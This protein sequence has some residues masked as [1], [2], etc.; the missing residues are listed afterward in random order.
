LILLVLLAGCSNPMDAADDYERILTPPCRLESDV[1]LGVDPGQCAIVC[2]ESGFTVNHSLS[3]CLGYQCCG[4]IGDL[5]DWNTA[6]VL[7][8]SFQHD[9]TTPADYTAETVPCD[10]LVDQLEAKGR[11]YEAP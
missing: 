2:G 10:Q 3:A 1:T 8:D 9:Q 11:I 7:R 4:L 5:P 6:Y